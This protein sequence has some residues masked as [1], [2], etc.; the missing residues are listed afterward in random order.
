M[1]QRLSKKETAAWLLERDGFL[2]C[3]HRRPDGD[4]LGSA[5]AL[6]AGLRAAGKE[7]YVLENPETTE[8]YLEYVADYLAPE[9]YEPLAVITVDTA[10]AGILQINAGPYAE[11]VDLCIDHHV[12]NTDY[13]AWTC[14]DTGRAA[15][16]E[17]VYAVLLELN[18]NISAAC[19]LPLYVALATDTGCFQYANVNADTFETAAALIRAGADHWAVNK[20]LFR[21]K[22]RGRMALDGA[23]LSGL[24]FHYGEQLAVAV[25]TLDLMAHCGVTEDDLDDIANIPNQAEGVRVGIVV[26]ELEDGSCKISVRAAPGVNANEICQQFGGGGH[27]GAAGCTVD[28]PPDE[29]AA[30]LVAAAGAALG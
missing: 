7:A 11:A 26:R 28:M 10:D 12:S 1:S 9:D 8:R 18:G 3:T 2:V 27:P 15:C 13:A 23:L 6:C 17:V 14:L 29:A 5:A 24:Q 22:S 19:A 30:M 4:A 16:G 21:T 20:K 25:V